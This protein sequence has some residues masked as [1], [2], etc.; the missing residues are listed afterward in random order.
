MTCTSW[1]LGRLKEMRPSFLLHVIRQHVTPFSLA[2]FVRTR[3]EPTSRLTSNLPLDHVALGIGSKWGQF[4]PLV[5]SPN[6][7]TRVDGETEI[8]LIHHR[9][10]RPIWTRIKP[11]QQSLV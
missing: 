4:P 6:P 11:A 2:S 9:F 8:G 7:L 3:S 10:S 5:Y 1:G